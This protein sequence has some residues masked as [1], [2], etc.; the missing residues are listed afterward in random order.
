MVDFWQDGDETNNDDIP[1]IR[2]QLVQHS[3]FFNDYSFEGLDIER[4]KAY[5]KA[6]GKEYEK[7]AINAKFMNEMEDW[8]LRLAQEAILIPNDATNS[9]ILK[10]VF[11]NIKI[12]VNET[13]EIAHIHENALIKDNLMFVQVSTEW[14]NAPYKKEAGD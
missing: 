4:I 10:M 3:T 14:L 8:Y 11:P 1:P 6:T 5:C 2:G 9:E 13:G 12:T 7:Q